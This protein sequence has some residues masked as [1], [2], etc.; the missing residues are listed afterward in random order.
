MKLLELVSYFRNGGSFED[1]CHSKSLD[2]ESEVVEVYMEKPFD[3]N[4][5][6]VFFEIAKTNGNIEYMSNGVKYST[7]FDF[8]YFLDAIEESNESQN[9]SLTDKDIAARLFLYAIHDA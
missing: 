5:D 1:F 6:L 3:L 8:Y 2:L 7:L 4:K 9:K